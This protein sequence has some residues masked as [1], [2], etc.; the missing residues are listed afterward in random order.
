[1]YP[2]PHMT[3]MYPPP[4][5][6]IVCVCPS[7]DVRARVPTISY[8]YT[9]WPGQSDAIRGTDQPWPVL[10]A[11]P[12]PF[13]PI[14]SP[15]IIILYYISKTYYIIFH[16]KKIFRALQFFF[17]LFQVHRLSYYI[18]KA[19]YDIYIYISYHVTSCYFIYCPILCNMR[20]ILEYI[21]RTNCIM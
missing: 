16:T 4:H 5:S 15:P 3:H 9:P 20:D 19:R 11:L 21:S 2:P 13:S 14:P 17:H 1:M 18:V 12:L 10:P 8:F 7:A 6:V